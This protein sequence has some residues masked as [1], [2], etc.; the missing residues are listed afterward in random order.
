MSL[1]IC[2]TSVIILIL[3]GC[4]QKQ[5]PVVYD[6]EFIRSRNVQCGI[7][8][9]EKLTA[10]I[11]S[12]ISF[13]GFNTNIDHPRYLPA[14]KPSG[15]TPILPN[16]NRTPAG[17]ETDGRLHLN[18][19][20]K[21]GDF[22]METSDRPGLKMVAAGEVN[23]QISIPSPLIRVTEGTAITARI[24]N[25]LRDSTITVFGLQKRPY[26]KSDSLFVLP[27]E[28]G[29]VSFEAGKAGTYMY[30]IQ[31]GKG[32]PKKMFGDEEEQLAGAFIVDP[33]GGSKDDRVFV[34][35]IFSSQHK[36]KNA[37][38]ELVESL[39]VNG[40]SWPFTEIIEPAVG[41]TL[42]WRVINASVRNHPMHLHGFYFDVL[43]RG[44]TQESS[45]FDKDQVK[46]VVT[47]TLKGRNTM[48]MQWIP[49][50]P[51]NW[52]F[53]CHLSFHVSAG[54]RLPG[55]E[56]LDP[57]D[58]TQH[59][60]GLVLGIKVKEGETDIYSKGED[61]HLTL[62][63]HQADKKSM[64]IGLDADM[65]EP[66]FKPGSLL[67]LKQFQTTYVTVKNKMTED[68]SIHWHGLEIDSWADGVPNWSY[69]DGKSS[70]ILKP[71]EEF[72]YK[73]SLMRAGTFVYHSH[74]NDV[75]QLT[76]GIYGP[77][78][79]MGENEKYNPNLDHFYIL[80]WK[81]PFPGSTDDLD[82]NGW[83]EV[84]VQKA[85]TG[86]MHRIRLI[87]IGPAGGAKLHFTKN[88]ET[89]PVLAFAK[90]GADLPSAQQIT[91]EYPAKIYAGE[92]ADYMFNPQEPGIYELNVKY[93]MGK[94]KQI[95]EV[96]SH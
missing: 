25:T 92:T 64:Y 23:K 83:N 21:W 50:R 62:Y 77:M 48:A 93:M 26:V 12:L 29:E 28:T 96:K 5:D 82:L 32:H 19:E 36:D 76:K 58:E 67:V 63:A 71:N 80:G 75:N 43:E 89:I 46:T 95:W 60:A 70:P 35:N 3:S 9:T 27:G 22:R 52:L 2:L 24:T 1:R 49:K 88:G 45:I 42:N 94:W 85:K 17:T 11:F 41:D 55:A 47:E 84:P 61:R 40:R 7:G 38:T 15:L 57:E 73:L 10:G 13:E 51:G 68:T 44:E 20:V 86:E 33:V 37:K 30:W 14:G 66:S 4:D 39:T 91:L 16:D 69:S 65:P 81:N 53:H 79:V 59:M 6:S 34:M 74:W 18:L 56:S 31:L 72:T 78:I 54:V 90:D 8:S 87:N